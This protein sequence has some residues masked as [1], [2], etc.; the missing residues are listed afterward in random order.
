MLDLIHLSVKNELMNGGFGLM[1]GNECRK[2]AG[3]L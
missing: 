1:N 3:W 2:R